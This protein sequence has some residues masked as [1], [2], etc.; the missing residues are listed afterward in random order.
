MDVLIYFILSIIIVTTNVFAIKWHR[1]GNIHLW[2]SGLLLAVV[3]VI[4]GF[5]AGAILVQVGHSGG[6]SGAGG[7]IAGA[8]VGIIIVANGILLFL[9]GLATKI[10]KLFNK[11]N[12]SI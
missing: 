9:V 10:G 2:I 7:A 3:G 11:N 8:F 12:T 1:N 5:I 4:F 6:T